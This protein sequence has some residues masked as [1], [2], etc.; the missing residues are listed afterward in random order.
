MMHDATAAASKSRTQ[1][2]VCL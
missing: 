2:T 1:C